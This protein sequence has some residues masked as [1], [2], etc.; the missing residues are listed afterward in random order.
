MNLLLIDSDDSFAGPL[1]RSLERGGV[2]VALHDDGRSGFEAARGAPP[3]AIVL[4]VELGDKPTAGYTW[5]QRLKKDD[6]TR[7]IPLVLVSSLATRETFEQHGRLRHRADEYLLKPFDAAM[8]LRV[9]GRHV[10]LPAGAL[11]VCTSTLHGV[12]VPT[13]E[14]LLDA[15]D[16][17]TTFDK[18]FDLMTAGD[19]GGGAGPP[20]G[21]ALEYSSPG[22]PAATP[23]P[24][25]DPAWIDDGDWQ[26][27]GGGPEE[28]EKTAVFELPTGRGGGA[29]YFDLVEEV[30]RKQA[31]IVRLED[32]LARAGRER[33]EARA[34][35]EATRADRESLRTALE[36]AGRERDAARV[37]ADQLR[38]R[39]AEV[40]AEL[41]V[42]RQDAVASAAETER[43]AAELSVARGEASVD[44]DRLRSRVNE[45]EDRLARMG[46]EL[47]GARSELEARA[48]AVARA[49]EALAEASAALG[50][51][52]P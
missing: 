41:A 51:T 30:A 4:A 39:V 37:E 50:N 49:R 25:G 8:L 13:P 20:A 52:T 21:G 29:E 33:N 12:A 43:V 5:C 42:G 47:R 28:A 7:A 14:E 1:K 31:E 9:L 10:A 17:L 35:L 6:T 22:T 16:E 26:L 40:E 36:E 27:P 44:N 38:V 32:E 11:D 23:A 46:E 3:D 34:V 24:K 48:A 15:D 18:A 45:L 2:T 19:V